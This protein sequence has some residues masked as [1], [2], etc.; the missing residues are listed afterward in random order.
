MTE[1]LTVHEAAERLGTDVMTLVE[2]VNVGDIVPAI[3]PK[4]RVLSGGE[5]WKNWREIRLSEDDIALFKAEISRRRFEDFKA[6]YSDIYTPDSRPGGRGLEFGPGWTNILKTYADGLRSLV[7]EGKQAAWLR[8]G[9]EK[10]G[11]LRLFSDYILS[12]E[13]QVIDLHR[14]AHRSSLVTCQECGEPA[15]LRFGYGVCLT[16][17]ERHKHIVGEPD[18]SRDGIILDLDAWT[19][20]ESETKE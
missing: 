16:L 12:V 18:P 4:P 1:L 13:R 7:I 8:W 19:L 11:A 9:K 20:K 5:V 17:C 15:R 14:E 2:I 10:F 3:S 6:D